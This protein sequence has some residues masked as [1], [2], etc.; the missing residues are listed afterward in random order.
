MRE[1][2]DLIQAYTQYDALIINCGGYSHTSI[3]I[4]DAIL[5]IRGLDK[6][7]VEVH[8][9]NV[10]SREDFRH[11]LVTAKACNAVIGGCGLNGYILA[12]IQILNSGL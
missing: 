3:A 9:S 11:N 12:M 4:M 7:V 6:Y 5:A 8:V 2:I 10:H 1:I